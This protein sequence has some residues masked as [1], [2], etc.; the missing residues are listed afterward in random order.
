METSWKTKQQKLIRIADKEEHGWEVVKHYLSDELT[1]ISRDDKA[2]SKAR[3]EALASVTKR[4]AKDAPSPSSAP[5][6]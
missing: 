1:S 3:K 2:L 5:R 6:P 4:K